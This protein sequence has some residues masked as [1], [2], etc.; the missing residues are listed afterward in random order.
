[1]ESKFS[2]EN[3][4]SNVNFYFLEWVMREKWE[5]TK[6]EL[7]PLHH[8]VELELVSRLDHDISLEVNTTLIP[9]LCLDD[10]QWSLLQIGDFS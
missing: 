8:L 3:F 7:F 2:I 1:M 4:K 6:C 10:I 5:S 9:F